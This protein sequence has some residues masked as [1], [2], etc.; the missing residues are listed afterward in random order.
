MY[1]IQ[2]FLAAMLP[3]ILTTARGT[4]LDSVH[5]HMWACAYPKHAS[6]DQDNLRGP[7]ETNDES[8][9]KIQVHFVEIWW[10]WGPKI[11]KKNT[12]WPLV[13]KICNV[14]KKCKKLKS[15]I[16]WPLGVNKWDFD[17]F[18]THFDYFGALPDCKGKMHDI[19]FVSHRSQEFECFKTSKTGSERIPN[20]VCSFS[21]AVYARLQ[22]HAHEH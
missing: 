9:V 7:S 1:K 10:R 11:V 3:K 19:E 17:H 14:G 16:F 6:V 13:A 20:V 18:C 5:A 2:E 15:Y 12:F 21:C 8:L 22:V 4:W